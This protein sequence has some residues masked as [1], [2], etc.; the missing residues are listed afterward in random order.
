VADA[1]PRPRKRFGQHFLTDPRILARIAESAA[2]HDVESVIEIGPGR[3]ALTD[4]LVGRAKRLVAIEIDRDLASRLRERYA[5]RSDVEIVDG[6][7]LESDLASLATPPFAVVGNLPY[8]I[9]TP[10]LFHVL[11]SP[12]PMR[13]VFLVQ[14]EVAERMAA[15]AGAEAY[16]ALSVGVQAVADIEHVMRVRA[17]AFTPPPKVDSS[18]VRLTPRATRLVEPKDEERF[19][20]L[21]QGTFGFRRKQMRRVLRELAG[22]EPGV[23]TELLERARIDPEARPETL[24]PETFVELLRTLDASNVPDITTRRS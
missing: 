3:G 1:A 5:E 11:R 21:V 15:P 16:G 24:S 9:T 2:P 17:G 12:L 18:V 4:H 8:Y 6:D 13:A 7:V 22:I 19:R 14:R 20:R 23:A 10:I